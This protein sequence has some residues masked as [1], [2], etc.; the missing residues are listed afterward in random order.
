MDYR[1]ENLL[2]DDLYADAV[3]D[4]SDHGGSNRVY[5]LTRLCNDSWY[6]LEL[7]VCI[8]FD[9]NAYDANRKVIYRL[10]YNQQ[11]GKPFNW[12]LIYN[13]VK[14]GLKDYSEKLELKLFKKYHVKYGD[15]QY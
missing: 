10:N 2:K 14:H 15:I 1:G 8:A 13:A 5:D 3:I 11:T 4:I 6:P 9:K 12:L 7:L